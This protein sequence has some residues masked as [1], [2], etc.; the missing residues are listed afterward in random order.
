VG[1]RMSTSTR[2]EMPGGLIEPASSLT[3][4]RRAVST[5]C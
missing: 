4:T 2:S 5:V 3:V 1:A